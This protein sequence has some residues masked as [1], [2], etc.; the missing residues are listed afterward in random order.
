VSGFIE[1]Q[2]LRL[3]SRRR[4]YL[5]GPDARPVHDMLLVAIDL[6]DVAFR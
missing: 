3:P 2:G 6:S 1:A 5:R 4:A